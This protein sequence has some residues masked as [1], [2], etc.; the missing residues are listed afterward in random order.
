MNNN[1]FYKLFNNKEKQHLIKYFEE[2]NN[3]ITLNNK[4]TKLIINDFENG[5]IYFKKHGKKIEEILKILSLDNFG[6]CYKE[7][8]NNWYPLD[9]SAKIYPLAMKENWMN[10]FRLSYYLKEDIVPEIFQIALL[11]T[12]KRFPT[13]RTS[14]RKGF[15]WHYID[16][17]KKRFHVY[18]DK[19]TPCSY[20]NVSNIGKQSFKAVYYKNRISVEYF[21]ILTD[22]YGGV[23]FISTL[24]GTY[25]KLLGKNI[26]HNDI[27]LNVND[28]YQEEELK[29][30]FIDKERTIKTQSLIENQAVQIDGKLSNIKPC[31]ILHFDIN[32]NDIKKVAKDKNATITE[33]ILTYLFLTLSYSTSQKGYIKIQVPVNMRKYYK[34]KTLRNFSLYVIVSINRN[35]IK[36]FAS[37]LKE[38]QKQ[39][40]E[41][42]NANY[43]NKTMTYANKLVQSIKYIPIFIKKPIAS[44]VYDFAGDKAMT[45]VLSN[46]GTIDIPNDMKNHVE[47]MDFI[48]GTAITNR[49]LFSMIT[50]SDI[51]TLTI[52]KFTT[53]TS[54]ENILY[55]ILKENNIKTNIHGSEQYENRK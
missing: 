7:N 20:I 46:L 21:H 39:M 37:V 38:V 6:D 9:N 22:G 29:D 55:N 10:V 13:F 1:N 53:N 35:K 12:M 32:I 4:Q 40:N 34:S 28:K 25:L 54:V 49:V 19:M 24:V 48:L 42:N 43:L 50:C 16:E 15:F 31:Q 14:I 27:V 45:T 51:L 36:D 47:K 26:T 2:L 44:I 41:K 18:E 3:K 5:I 23:V 33:L 8:S 52:C 30:E 11:L 17:I